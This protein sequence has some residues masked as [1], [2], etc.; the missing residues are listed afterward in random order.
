M[1]IVILAT[2]GLKY[3]VFVFI[4]TNIDTIGFPKYSSTQLIHLLLSTRTKKSCYKNAV[5]E[6][7]RHNSTCN[8]ATMNS[9]LY[10]GPNDNIIHYK[11][12]SLRNDSNDR[13]ITIKTFQANIQ[14]ELH[15]WTNHPPC[16]FSHTFVVPLQVIFSFCI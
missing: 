16:T 8:D 2:N 3:R 6:E 1:H 9:S 12:S 14:T 7:K 13:R 11:K 10:N 4:H 5:V 15:Y